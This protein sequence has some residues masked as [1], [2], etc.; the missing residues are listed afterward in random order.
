MTPT[1]QHFFV[2][3]GAKNLANRGEFVHDE[4]GNPSSP[5]V[6]KPFFSELTQTSSQFVYFNGLLFCPLVQG[7][8]DLATVV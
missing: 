7:P 1:L 5:Q 4:N 6:D 8:L 2:N 3:F